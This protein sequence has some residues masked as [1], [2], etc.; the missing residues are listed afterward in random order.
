MIAA[1]SKLSY[2]LSVTLCSYCSTHAWRPSKYLNHGKKSIF[3]EELLEE[4]ADDS[5]DEDEKQNVDEEE[6]Y[7][8]DELN[9]YETKNTVKTDEP[10]IDNETDLKQ[11]LVDIDTNVGLLKSEFF[12]GITEEKVEEDAYS[13]RSMHSIKENRDKTQDRQLSGKSSELIFI[14]SIFHLK[15]FTH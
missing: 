4:S 11:P 14:S 7:C 1:L 9:H 2:I 8:E 13:I 15:L 12:I 6:N 3:H 5:D 10:S